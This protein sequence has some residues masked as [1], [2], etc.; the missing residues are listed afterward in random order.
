LREGNNE[1]T[2]TINHET[3]IHEQVEVYSSSESNSPLVTSHAE[4]LIAREIRDI[5]VPSTHDL[6]SSLQTMP[7][8]VA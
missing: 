8:V 7:E 6:R 1:A 2:F 5:P 3:E 4:A